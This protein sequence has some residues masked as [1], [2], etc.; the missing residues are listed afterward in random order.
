MG[1]NGSRRRIRFQEGKKVSLAS[2][3][4]PGGEKENR[5]PEKKKGLKKGQSAKKEK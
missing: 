3:S 4:G 1:L 5:N 2:S